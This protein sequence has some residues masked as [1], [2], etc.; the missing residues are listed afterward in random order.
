MSPMRHSRRE[1]SRGDIFDQ[2][3][4]DLNALRADTTARSASTAEACATWTK[5]SSVAGLTVSKVWPSLESTHSPSIS[6]CLGEDSNEETAGRS[7]V[8]SDM[9][10]L[11]WCGVRG[12]SCDR[13]VGAVRGGYL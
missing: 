13:G 2:A 4:P 3:E 9:G 10:S 12:G 5:T 1:R 6:S 11:P 8:F 7:W